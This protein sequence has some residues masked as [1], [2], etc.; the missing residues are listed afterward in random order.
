MNYY[1]VFV[2]VHS[3]VCVVSG[4]V[5]CFCLQ[6]PAAVSDGSKL[7]ECSLDL[8]LVQPESVLQHLS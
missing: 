1:S 4:L 3:C 6:C 7:K 5:C 2:S 8:L